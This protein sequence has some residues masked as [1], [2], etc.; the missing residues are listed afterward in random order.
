MWSAV[1][2]QDQID[3]QS[4]YHHDCESAPQPGIANGLHVSLRGNEEGLGAAGWGTD[5]RKA[6]CDPDIDFCPR[7]EGIVRSWPKC[8]YSAPAVDGD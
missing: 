5:I 2:H 1:A 3:Q 8:R 6:P 7:G 4:C